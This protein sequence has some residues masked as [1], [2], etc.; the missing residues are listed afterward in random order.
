MREE[1]S[2]FA[3]RMKR[4]ISAS[5]GSICISEDRV[6]QCTEEG[7][8]AWRGALGRERRRR[9]ENAFFSWRERAGNFLKKNQKKW[10]KKI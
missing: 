5:V 6:K 9:R 10:K 7:S 4:S 2:A 1:R 3:Y 8:C